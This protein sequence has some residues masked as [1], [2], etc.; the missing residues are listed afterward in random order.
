M[1]GR[2]AKMKKIY[3]IGYND[4]YGDFAKI[5]DSKGYTLKFETIEEAE[6]YVEKWV[7]KNYVDITKPIKIMKGWEVIKEI[8]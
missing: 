6:K 4:L 8:K 1:K 5:W 7:D 3:S 2:E